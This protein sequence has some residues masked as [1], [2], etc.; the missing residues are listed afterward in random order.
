M[1]LRDF[2]VYDIIRRN[3]LVC[4]GRDALV[5]RN[6]RITHGEYKECCD[7]CAAG[8]VRAGVGRGDRLA[9]IAGNS[10][11]YVILYGAAAGIGAIVLPVN[12]RFQ[13]DEIQY[14]LQDCTPTLLFTGSE[15][16]QVARDASRAVPSIR[17]LYTIGPR[18]EKD[19]LPPFQELL[20][21]EADTAER[22]VSGETG[23]VIMHTAAVDGRPRGALLSQRNVIAITTQALAEQNRD[24]TASHLCI[25]PLFHI[26]ALASVLTVLHCGGKNV[27]ME[28]FDP[29]QALRLIE[30][31]RVAGFGS[32]APILT[33]LLEEQERNPRDLS[34]LRAIGGLEDPGSIDRF[35]E[36]A[37]HASFFSAYGQTEAMAVT[38]CNRA[39]RPGSAGRPSLLTRVA[40]FDDYDRDVSPGETGEICVRSPTVFQGYWGRE[41]ETAQT[42]RSG[43]HHTGDIGRFDSDGYLWYVKRKS[44]KE[45]IKPGG[46][47]VYPAEVELALMSHGSLVEVCV[48][49]V[50][51]R[52]WGEA[53]KAVCV[54]K[55]GA[56]TTPREL[57][58]HVA[59]RI[60]RYKK[61]GDIIFVDALPRT[62]AGEIDR[63][64][65]KRDHGGEY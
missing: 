53:V 62:E 64:Q 40:L 48:I 36:H 55:P 4:S 60:A 7:R 6:K 34:S 56:V 21:D 65:V 51:D 29:V 35:L 26:A 32:F 59:S 27:I 38:G 20:S 11:E 1:G 15:Y 8:L 45:L 57:I 31:E 12:W 58:D 41:E 37:S 54:L 52:T 50:P 17:A 18:D 9:V 5:F 24:E 46:E 22:D 47:N 16:R 33:M 10:D 63:E 30:S 39:E 3:A 25:L 49:G 43:W 44:H 13:R 2:G 23:Y 28:R 42:F 14:V 19:D 61:P